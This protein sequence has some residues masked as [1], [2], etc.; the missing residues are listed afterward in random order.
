MVREE[1]PVVVAINGHQAQSAF[2]RLKPHIVAVTERTRRRKYVLR[3]SAA[4][5]ATVFIFCNSSRSRLA[6]ETLAAAGADPL[7]PVAR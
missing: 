4:A 3:T 6:R 2:K 5:G 1:L 7:R